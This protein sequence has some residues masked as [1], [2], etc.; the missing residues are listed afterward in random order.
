MFLWYGWPT[1]GVRDNCQR[2]LPSVNL[3]HAAIRIWTCAEPEFKIW[4][5]KLVITTTPRY[6]KLAETLY[7]NG[8]NTTDS[9]K[10]VRIKLTSKF[11]YVW[12]KITSLW[13]S[14][15][16]E[17]FWC[18]IICATLCLSP[19]IGW[20]LILCKV[21]PL[22]LPYMDWKVGVIKQGAIILINYFLQ[23]QWRKWWN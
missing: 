12:Q 21:V 9:I 8:L 10:Y 17:Q 5:V 22:S 3:R 7:F 11:L 20:V 6:H 2:S 4:W 13:F 19:Y 14:L 1:K 18:T 23:R 15:N 16:N